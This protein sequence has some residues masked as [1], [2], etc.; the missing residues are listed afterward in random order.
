MVLEVEPYRSARDVRIRREP[1]AP[2]RVAEHHEPRRGADQY[3]L[4]IPDAAALLDRLRPL[5]WQRL[6]AAGIDRTG[7]D[8]VIS[9]FGAHECN[10]I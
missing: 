7:R 1:I 2:E 6:T 3:Y 4:R 8:I 5:F 9:T 10:G